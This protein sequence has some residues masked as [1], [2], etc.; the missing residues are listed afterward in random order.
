VLKIEDDG[1][2]FDAAFVLSE[3]FAPE[4]GGNGLVNIRRRAR[5]LGG[6][7]RIESVEG[8]G[9]LVIL[10]APLHAPENI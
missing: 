2:G 9:T 1:R 6:T 4:T 5:E 10:E 3:D 8:A 7:C